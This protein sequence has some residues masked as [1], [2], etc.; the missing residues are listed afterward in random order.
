MQD[1]ENLLNEKNFTPVT[2]EQ[3]ERMDSKFMIS[4][5]ENILKLMDFKL[6]N[7]ADDQPEMD[8]SIVL[9]IIAKAFKYY[10][11]DFDAYQ[12]W[13][14]K[15]LELIESER[16]QKIED[17]RA[18]GENLNDPR[19][20]SLIAVFSMLNYLQRSDDAKGVSQEKESKIVNIS[21]KCDP[22]I[23]IFPLS[24]ITS[25]II[26]I[27]AG[28]N[29]PVDLAN[30]LQFLELYFSISY[31][32]EYPSSYLVTEKQVNSWRNLLLTFNSESVIL[33]QLKP[34]FTS[35]KEQLESMVTNLSTDVLFIDAIF[36]KDSRIELQEMKFEWKKPEHKLDDHVWYLKM[37][38]DKVIHGI[39]NMNMLGVVFIKCIIFLD[40]L[41][42]SSKPKCC[43]F[44]ILIK[45]L[46]PVADYTAKVNMFDFVYYSFLELKTSLNER[47]D[48][49]NDIMALWKEYMAFLVSS[50]EQMYQAINSLSQKTA[51][52]FS[53]EKH[54]LTLLLGLFFESKNAGASQHFVDLGK[55]WHALVV[56]FHIPELV[57]QVYSLMVKHACEPLL[58]RRVLQSFE[59]GIGS[60]EY[61]TAEKFKDS[62]VKFLGILNSD[63][64][65][66]NCSHVDLNFAYFD[67]LNQAEKY[68]GLLFKVNIAICFYQSQSQT[69][70]QEMEDGEEGE[71]GMIDEFMND[72]QAAYKFFPPPK[73]KLRLTSAESLE[74]VSKKVKA[75]PPHLINNP[76]VCFEV[77]NFAH[78]VENLKKFWNVLASTIPASVFSQCLVEVIKTYYPRDEA[79]VLDSI[80]VP[81]IM[82]HRWAVEE[83]T[84]YL[85]DFSTKKSDFAISAE[86]SPFE[87][88]SNHFASKKSNETEIE[89]LFLK[90]VTN[91]C[92]KQLEKVEFPK[93]GILKQLAAKRKQPSTAKDR[94]ELYRFLKWEVFPRE[95]ITVISNICNCS[96]SNIVT[97]YFSWLLQ[98]ISSKK[99]SLGNEEILLAAVLYNLE[100]KHSVMEEF[101]KCFL[102]EGEK[103]T[104][105]FVNY[106][107]LLPPIHF[108]FTHNYPEETK[109]NELLK[110]I[111]SNDVY[112]REK[113]TQAFVEMV[114]IESN[115]YMNTLAFETMLFFMTNHFNNLQP[116]QRKLAFNEFFKQ[117]NIAKDNTRIQYTIKKWGNLIS[118]LNPL[119]FPLLDLYADDLDISLI[120]IISN[121]V[122]SCLGH[123][124]AGFYLFTHCIFTDSNPATRLVRYLLSNEPD[125]S[126]E[127]IVQRL[128]VGVHRTLTSLLYHYTTQTDM[129]NLEWD[130]AEGNT[131]K[132]LKVLISASKDFMGIILEPAYFANILS[133]LT[134]SKL[135][136]SKFIV[137]F[138]AELYKTIASLPQ[139]EIDEISA[140]QDKIWQ[141]KFHDVAQNMIAKELL[142]QLLD[143][144]PHLLI[145]FGK[146]SKIAYTITCFCMNKLYELD[147][148]K[149]YQTLDQLSAYTDEVLI[150][151]YVKTWI[152][153]DPNSENL[154]KLA[155]KYA[156]TN[157]LHDISVITVLCKGPHN[158][159][160]SGLVLDFLDGIG[161]A[162]LTDAIPFLTTCLTYPKFY[163]QSLQILRKIRNRIG[164]SKIKNGKWFDTFI[165]DII[166]RSS[167]LKI[168]SR[169]ILHTTIQEI[170]K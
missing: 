95:F 37:I 110:T 119:Y 136:S 130:Q 142:N 52:L 102:L 108:Y 124:N 50:Q 144:L 166:V 91:I 31:I 117:F 69:E 76:L 39:P 54:L 92:I 43:K 159:T 82:Q 100:V 163:K 46:E 138:L 80:L 106:P 161:D 157:S 116:F 65:A 160:T 23:I 35:E 128:S 101:A 155:S 98:D 111:L 141:L 121:H 16:I 78:K 81:F 168:G 55:S 58:V 169:A 72:I 73:L 115:N 44:Q 164:N 156:T 96:G 33:S 162:D 34:N 89:M 127:L 153:T 94:E 14:D 151:P 18:K 51:V 45:L 2:L 5:Q 126:K 48:R 10:L 32:D 148:E 9:M 22:T 84:P 66:A 36:K 165:R 104:F 139:I 74:H 30:L 125:E 137:E 146:S 150:L 123:K 19:I 38:K 28:G 24:C 133:L 61:S 6:E 56:R 20:Y 143:L 53:K 11:N 83:F 21:A 26:G 25:H 60:K 99:E 86:S 63:S 147:R 167:D 17:I 64:P 4:H 87:A 85:V 118:T 149:C 152:F 140:G 40:A 112:Q 41:T 62:F 70:P 13:L 57:A 59:V 120:S 8:Y 135:K 71:E 93:S 12:V 113:D 27:F 132:V 109:R 107:L 129:E 68:K 154:L 77:I 67:L 75:E 88:I 3:I 79:L 122:K 1:L 90:T 114:V 47:P 49:L 131:F 145:V 158:E 103:V 170:S 29:S 97:G 7:F 134:N 15:L 105:D 42:T